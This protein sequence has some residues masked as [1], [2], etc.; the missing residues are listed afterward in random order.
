MSDQAPAGFK[1]EF[2]ARITTLLQQE[3]SKLRN[4]VMSGSHTGE[5][6]SVTD[7]IGKVELV[8]Q[9][10][11]HAKTP[12]LNTPH[13]RRWVEPTPFHGA[14]L[15]DH[16]DKLQFNVDPQPSYVTNFGMAAG[17]AIDSIII[18]AFFATAKTGRNV[19]SGTEAFD[20][21]S[22][23]VAAGGVGLTL[24]KLREGIRRMKSANVDVEREQLF[25]AV[26]AN[27]WQDLMSETQVLSSDYNAGVAPIRT[28]RLPALYNCTIIETQMLEA[29]GGNQL[30]PLW[31]KSGMHLGIW[32]DIQTEVDRRVD[33]SYAW[34]VYVR[35][36]AG[37]TR[38]EQG[39]VVRILCA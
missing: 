4:A 7:Q 38:L 6:A 11:R 33:L 14:D 39:K 23:E 25:L 31:C 1:T 37:A 5:Q 30:V 18:P 17:R 19:T 36:M 34:Q 15:I 10:T 28:G 16:I 35:V 3:G 8:Q 9:T 20:A 13:T 29:S 12:H 27:E 2:Q 21:T 24:A 26:T 22:Y 32:N